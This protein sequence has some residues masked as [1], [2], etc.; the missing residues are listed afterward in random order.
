MAVLCHGPIRLSSTLCL[1]PFGLIPVGAAY[2]LFVGATFAFYVVV[3]RATAGN[4][5]L[6]LLVVFLPAIQVTMACGQNGFLTAGLIGL[7]CLFFEDRPIL[8][9][10]ALG[11]MVIKPHLAIAFGAYAI[12]RRSWIVVATAAAVLLASSVICTAMF[13]VQIWTDLLQSFR[14]FIGLLGTGILF[15]ISDDIRLC[16]A[17]NCRASGLDGFSR[18]VYCRF[19]RARGRS[20]FRV[21]ENAIASWSWPHRGSIGV[22]QPLCI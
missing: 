4:N 15:P 20:L 13:G 16:I 10:L 7:V 2:F 18:P 14:D 6:L 9:G 17:A 3:L 1:H 8:A 12:L 21:P 5:F 22:H 11:L 19:S